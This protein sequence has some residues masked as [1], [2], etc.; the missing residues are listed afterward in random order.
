LIAPPLDFGAAANGGSL[1]SPPRSRTTPLHRIRKKIRV[2]ARAEE[3]VYVFICF[4]VLQLFKF[5]P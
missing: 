3:R 4:M 5:F 1:I 2:K